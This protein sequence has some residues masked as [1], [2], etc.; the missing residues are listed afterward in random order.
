MIILGFPS[1]WVKRVLLKNKN[2]TKIQYNIPIYQA[3]K[4]DSNIQLCRQLSKY[5][6]TPEQTYQNVMSKEGKTTKIA[7]FKT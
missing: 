5:A 1:L 7:S 3:S 6:Q 2:M 4:R